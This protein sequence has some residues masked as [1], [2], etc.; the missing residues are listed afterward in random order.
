MQVCETSLNCSTKTLKSKT[1]KNDR[2]EGILAI[3]ETKKRSIFCMEPEGDWPTRQSMIQDII[4][5]C[6][7]VFFT[8]NHLRLWPA[9]WGN[10][11]DSTSVTFDYTAVMEGRVD[12]MKSLESIPAADI[13]RKQ[14]IMKAH[15]HQLH[16]LHMNDYMKHGN[17]HQHSCSIDATNLL[18]HDLKEGSMH[19]AL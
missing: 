8:Q 15:K 13:E 12:I 19:T 18:L 17:N 11:I 5:N 6:I 4:L 3:F 14:R 9:F 10:F 16:Y 2:K 7:P 1:S